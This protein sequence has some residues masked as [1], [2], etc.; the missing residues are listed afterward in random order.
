M[1]PKR[2]SDGFSL[3]ELLVVIAIIGLLMVMAVPA[4]NS[5]KGSGGVTKAASD[6]AGALENAATYARAANTYVWVGFYE[7]DASRASSTPPTAGV[8]RLV[9]ATIFSKDGTQ[10]IDPIGSAQSITANATRTGQ[11]GR[12]IKLDNMHLGDVASPDAP[13]AKGAG[14]GFSER[15]SVA[16]GDRIGASTADTSYPFTVAQYTF[17]KVIQFSPEGIAVINSRPTVVPWVEIGLLPARGNTVDTATPNVVAL[18][19]SGINP[20]VRTYRK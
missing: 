2:Q 11:L 9:V 12:P 15:P 7:E 20:Q 16:S 8:G 3:I 5:I 1:F 4:F 10:I 14:R 13:N 19:V 18:Q 17:K 6:V